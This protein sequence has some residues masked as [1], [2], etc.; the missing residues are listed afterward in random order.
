M[1]KNVP[2]EHFTENVSEGDIVQE[3]TIDSTVAYRP[4]KQETQKRKQKA[5]DLLNKI[6]NKKN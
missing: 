1:Q 2:R 4:L 5:E 3:I 6:K